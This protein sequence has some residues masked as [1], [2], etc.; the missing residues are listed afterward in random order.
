MAELAEKIA[1]LRRQLREWQ[2]VLVAFSGG[3]DSTFLLRVAVEELGGRAL[4]VT[5]LSETYPRREYENACRL[6]AGMGAR[7][8]TVETGEVDI[9]GY[10]DNPPD[11]CYH[12]KS[13][14]FRQLRVLAD[15]HGLAVVCDGSNTDDTGDYRPGR[16]AAC[17][18]GVRSPLAELGFAKADIRQAARELGLPNWEQ[19]AFACLASRF[20][21]GQEIT[22]EK[23]AAVEQ[24]ENF[25]RDLGL[26]QVRV[27]HHGEVARIEVAP[28]NFPQILAK[29]DEI[30]RQLRACGFH[31]VALDLGGYRTGSMNE[32]LPA[33]AKQPGPGKGC[34]TLG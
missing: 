20:P 25:L 30:T 31:Y 2:S 26:G 12:C 1:A 8:L 16:R 11:R 9:P 32:T 19:P 34:Q 29:A 22:R 33:P 24:A 5:A 21:Y 13:E 4:G 6:A 3:V 27:R 28:A 17:E 15:A 23:L 7:L 10:R 14:L 18:L